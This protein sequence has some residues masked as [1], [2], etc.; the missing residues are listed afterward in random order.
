MYSSNL[1]EGLIFCLACSVH[2]VRWR[3]GKLVWNSVEIA[4]NRRRTTCTEHASTKSRPS[5]RLELYIFQSV[6]LW[7]PL[8]GENACKTQE[9]G[10][11]AGGGR[12]SKSLC[13]IV[14]MAGSFGYQTVPEFWYMWPTTPKTQKKQKWPRT[15]RNVALKLPKISLSKGYFGQFKGYI[16]CSGKFGGFF[17]SEGGSCHRGFAIVLKYCES[18]SCASLILHANCHSTTETRPLPDHKGICAVLGR[19]CL[20][21]LFVGG[22]DLYTTTA[23]R[24]PPQ[25]PCR[26]FGCICLFLLWYTPNLSFFFCL[27][28]HL[29]FQSCK[30]LWC[31]LFSL[32][33]FQWTISTPL[34]VS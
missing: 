23:R 28:R 21:A 22:Q 8:W 2:F 24:G 19:D 14:S 31:I 4:Q 33:N 27:L 15:A 3:F 16:L 10:V 6:T 26:L 20:R 13:A 18:I 17:A 12:H 7:A 11:G 9:D 1:S 32:R 5:K 29:S 30:H 25:T 34:K